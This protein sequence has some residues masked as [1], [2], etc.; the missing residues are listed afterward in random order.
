MTA[1]RWK[2]AIEKAIEKYK[3]S[4]VIQLATVDAERKIP[5]IRSLI[6]RAFLS[7][8]SGT[9]H[10]LVSTTDVRAP[11]AEQI[12]SNPWVQLVWWI[13]ETQEQF[14]ISGWAGVVP[15]PGNPLFQRFKQQVVTSAVRGGGIQTLEK[16]G[17]D[18][19]K[20]RDEIFA[21]LSGHM[22]ASWC[23]P[24]PSVELV[25]GYEESKKWPE[26][27]GDGEE[28]KE[29]WD[30]A[31]KNFGLLVVDPVEVDYVELG[32]VPNRR[33]RFKRDEAGVWKE[34]PIVP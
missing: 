8:S 26:R 25:G 13:D 32:V 12:A 29:N 9:N 28:D 24:A 10:V 31:M 27:V 17:L 7:D 15:E 33:T 14:R 23:H 11:K 22:K 19:E 6:F 5:Q 1:P 3:K 30:K 34:E 4:T 21:S 20:K 2:N 16:E 18:W